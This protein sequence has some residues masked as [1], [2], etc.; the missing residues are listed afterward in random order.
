MRCF[1]WSVTFS[2]LIQDDATWAEASAVALARDD[3]AAGGQE[4]RLEQLLQRT[5]T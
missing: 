1:H 5:Q 4:A 3:G 2:Q